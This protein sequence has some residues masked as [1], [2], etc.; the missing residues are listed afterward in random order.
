MLGR[1]SEKALHAFAEA[2]NLNTGNQDFS[3]GVFDFKVCQKPDG[4][5]YG[6]PDNWDCSPPNTETKEKAT[7]TPLS[8]KEKQS[9]LKA[10]RGVAQ[11]FLMKNVYGGDTWKKVSGNEWDKAEEKWAKTM[12]RNI[13]GNGDERLMT[14]L[15]TDKSFGIKIRNAMRMEEWIANIKD[16]IE[17]RKR[18]RNKT[19]LKSAKDLA[20]KTIS[21]LGKIELAMEKQINR[22][23]NTG[24]SE[25]EYE[26]E[27]LKS[28]SDIAFETY[29]KAWDKTEEIINKHNAAARERAN[30][31]WNNIDR[32]TY[33]CAALDRR[34]M[35]IQE[36]LLCANKYD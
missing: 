33:R 8:I 1:F 22:V 3:E 2:H 29:K 5:R 9:Y 36:Q 13:E 6:I 15:S 35:S 20:D 12:K 23:M 19:E 24:S 14:T 25:L 30:F 34:R 11:T 32:Q 10:I 26:L 18:W 27:I 16:L 28:M 4:G 17:D 21:K 7:N 31:Q